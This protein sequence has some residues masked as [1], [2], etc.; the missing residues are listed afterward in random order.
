MLAQLPV[1]FSLPPSFLPFESSEAM[2]RCLIT[3]GMCFLP[4][5]GVESIRSAVEAKAEEYGE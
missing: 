3:Q 2:H 1:F 5:P 4:G